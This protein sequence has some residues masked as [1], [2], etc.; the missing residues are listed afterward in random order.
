MRSLRRLTLWILC[1]TLQLF[2]MPITDIPPAYG[3]A[4][5][6]NF[7]NYLLDETGFSKGVC[8]VFGGDADL[9]L[10]IAKTGD[11]FVHVIDPHQEIVD[12]A[13]E[14]VDVQGRYGKQIIVEQCSLNPLPYVDNLLDV[15]FVPQRT[16]DNLDDFSLAE[17]MRVVRPQGV[18][19]MGNANPE[20]LLTEEDL[21]AFALTAPYDETSLKMGM[22]FIVGEKTCGLWVMIRKPAQKGVDDWP[23]WEHGPDNNPVSSDEVIQSPFMTK[24]LGAPFY[25]TM[26]MITTAS[27]GR[28]FLAMGHIAHHEREEPWLNTLLA[29]NAYNGT[30]LWTLKLPD[31]YLVHRSAYAATPDTFYMIDLD[32]SGCL[33]LDPE[34]GMEQGKIEV[35]DLVPGQ[36]KWMTLHDGVLYFLAGKEKDPSET[37]IVRSDYTHWSWGEL[38]RGYYT[39]RAPWGFGDTIAAYDIKNQHLRWMHNENQPIDSRAMSFGGGRLYFYGPDSHVGCLDAKTGDVVWT[40]DDPTLRKLIEEKGRGLSSTPGFR[41]MCFSVYTPDALFFEAQTRMNIVAVSLEDGRYLWHRK[42]STF[43]PN[44]MYVDGQLIVGIGEGGDT[45]EVNPLTGETIRDLGF[46][47]R[48]CARLTATPES[49]FCRGWVEG[50]TRYDRQTG[51][52]QFNGAFR[53]SC[54][55]GML[56]AFGHL[57]TGPWPCDCN[58]SVMGQIA[59]CSAGDFSLNQS[60]DDPFRRRRGEGDLS[61]VK[62]LHTDPRDWPTYRGGIARNSSTPVSIDDGIMQIWQ[63]K[64]EFPFEPTVPV[65]AG[66]WVF[67]GGDDGKVRAIDVTTGEL[68]WSHRTNGPILQPPTIWEGRAF[69]GSGDGCIYALEAATG[70]LLWKYRASPMERRIMVY[71]SL[72]STWPVNSGIVVQDG[73]VYAAA[74]IIDYDGTIL[75]ALDA[76]T[77]D[78]IWTNNDSGH[79]DANLRKGISAQGTMT[80]SQG[81]LWMAGG[82]VLSPAVYDLSN[83]AYQGAMP[84]DGSPQANRGEEIGLLGD[85]ILLG[86]KLRYTTGDNV[87]D[88]ARFDAMLF[89]EN[90]RAE[91]STALHDGKIPPVWNED[92]LIYID[93]RNSAPVCCSMEDVLNYIHQGKEKATVNPVWT[94][95]ILQGNDTVAMALARNRLLAVHSALRFRSFDRQWFLSLFDAEDAS[96]KG[97]FALSSPALTGG[98]LVDREGRILIVHKQGEITCFGD[99]EALRAF[100]SKAIE[101]GAGEEGRKKYAE[102]MQAALE[103][104]YNPIGRKS[105]IDN[106]KEQGIQVGQNA[107]RQGC[108]VDWQILGPIPWDINNPHAD[109]SRL[110]APD[111]HPK[112]KYSLNDQDYDWRPFRTHID[113]GAVA[114]DRIYGECPNTAIYAYTEFYC[115]ESKPLQL[116][117]GTNDGYRC[118]LNGKEES[119]F[120]GGRGYAADDDTVDVIAKEGVNR[121]LLKVTQHGND[122]T[123]SVRITDRNGKPFDLI[124]QQ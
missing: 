28:L 85:S 18:I 42:K 92:L 19:F 75:L 67:V 10:D 14:K 112:N 116:K 114:L 64:P 27:G 93:G 124:K 49:F 8:A 117:I 37:T 73:V 80:V 72:C 1:F 100:T 120:D 105:L 102:Q 82:N 78:L 74:G 101:K 90:G 52:V 35:A 77:G 79:L 96:P 60:K 86:G 48:S 3:A 122:W 47:K 61:N 36:W 5:A 11:F 51:E 58:L 71:G 81:K 26:P 94:A 97:Q 110:G 66:D 25:N 22:Q 23:V 6:A 109:E 44:I 91:R 107:M 83:G 4:H 108:L 99:N 84:L 59:L 20:G 123:Y 17:I 15:V 54:N 40:N 63:Y 31:G 29:R 16:A 68:Q 46:K 118:W 88:P 21:A 119:T 70:R 2:L 9:G 115:P 103:I 106:L 69:V 12:S 13:Q 53:P 33:M 65:C 57:Y 24:W 43:N 50:L 98:L 45:L 32:G 104:V 41:T 30:I 7:A 76:I 95:D 62:P 56:P 39:E 89:N 38:S 113:H 34:T 121:L 55:D 87:V 111:L